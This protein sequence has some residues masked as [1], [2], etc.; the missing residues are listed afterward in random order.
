MKNIK[1]EFTDKRII[2]ASGFA[3]VGGILVK[4]DLPQCSV[5]Q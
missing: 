2:P 5:G 4:S 3:V 1:I